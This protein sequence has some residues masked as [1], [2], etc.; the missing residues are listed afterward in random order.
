M[1][2]RLV[3][4][5]IWRNEKFGQ[6]DDLGR[7]LF[8]GMITN[9]DDDG[10]LK[11][12]AIYLKATI[13]PYDNKDINEIRSCI[14]KCHKQGLIYLYSINGSE[15]IQLMGWQEHQSIRKDR[16]QPS[17]IPLPDNH[18]T[19][20]GA[21]LDNHLTTDGMLNIS[22][23]NISKD[24]IKGD[25]LEKQTPPDELRNTVSK[26]IEKS[27]YGEGIRQVFAGLLKRRGYKT[28]K[29][30]GEA[31]SI[32]NMLKEGYTPDQILETWEKL[33][34]DDFWQGKELYMMSVEKQIGAILKDGTHKK[35]VGK[36]SGKPAK[37][38]W[39]REPGDHNYGR[40]PIEEFEYK[41]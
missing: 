15:Y 21:S 18:L 7:L 8:I 5:E 3:T 13:F 20:D 11:G 41:G 10:R 17:R 38:K 34:G 25:V 31:K 22:K 27:P 28:P 2:R 29:N 23:D 40:I 37:D 12:S 33:K 32:R 1:P 19:T 39:G 14:N 16:Y 24:N 36:I 6:L 30:P 26:I 35:G 4:S 9:A